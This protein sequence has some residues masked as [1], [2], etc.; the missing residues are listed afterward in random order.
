MRRE[1]IRSTPLW[2]GKAPRYDCAFVVEDQD[3]PG[4][5]GLRVVRVKMFFSFTYNDTSYPCELVEW[6]QWI[7]GFPDPKTRMWKVKP[8]YSGNDKDISVLHLDTFLC[9]AHLLPVFGSDPL[10]V[11]FHHTRWLTN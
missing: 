4:M 8:K 10:P 2:W 7:G 3:S 5:S 9:G 6:F 1:R 11:N